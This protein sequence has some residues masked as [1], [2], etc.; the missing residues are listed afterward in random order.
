MLD[1]VGY[2]IPPL[3]TTR[4]WSHLIE[5]LK[6]GGKVCRLADVQLGVAQHVPHSVEVSGLQDY[7]L[8]RLNF[9]E[10]PLPKSRFS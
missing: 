9:F 4:G 10:V 6:D 7:L 5:I 2:E 3:L 1:K 8:V